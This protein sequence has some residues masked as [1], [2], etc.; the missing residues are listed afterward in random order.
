[1]FNKNK[2]LKYKLIRG[3]VQ[4]PRN[5]KEGAF[6]K[7]VY[8]LVALRDIP[9]HGV[10][11]GDLGGIV[12]S[13]STL[14]HEGSCWISENAEVFGP[15]LVLN[16]AYIGDNAS[17][18]S[19]AIGYSIYIRD[20]VKITGDSSIEMANYNTGIRPAGPCYI[21]NN[22]HI[23][24]NAHIENTLK[25][26]GDAKIY[27]KAQLKNVKEVSDDSDI[28]GQVVVEK[29]AII[30]GNTKLSGKVKIGEATTIRNSEI[31]GNVFIPKHD[32]LG[33]VKIVNQAQINS[34]NFEK[35]EEVVHTP[36]V[37]SK[38][39]RLLSIYAEVTDKIATYETD[40]VKIIKYPSMTDRSNAA[41]LA[42]ALAKT[43]AERL[44]ADEECEESELLEAVKD[45]EATF[46]VAESE[47]LKMA[48][49]SLSE[50]ERRKVEKAK[51]L[52]NMA[53]NE[54]SSEQ[55]KK[56][57]FKQAFKHLEGV[58]VVPEVAVDTFRIKIGLKEIEA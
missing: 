6:K 1:M 3:K 18:R 57:S 13:K 7:R 12:T 25:I 24:E 26:S 10:K 49:T 38:K 46:M 9:E 2:D 21:G 15:V 58:L 52:L 23:Y 47:A 41:T 17:I 35:V 5:R 51:D 42:M 45:L 54:A 11:A 31:S 50:A 20:N 53:A 40:I 27:G 16:N 43:T 22:V 14:S 4:Y 19:G 30:I 34:R 37:S 56:V 8:R 48:A 29:D 33:E 36:K 39:N 28:S 32:L 44:V 55:E